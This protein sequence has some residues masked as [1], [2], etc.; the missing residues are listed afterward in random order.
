MSQSIFFYFP[1]AAWCC[2]QSCEH[3]AQ[4]KGRGRFRQS[5]H[6]RRGF[7]QGGSFLGSEA[8][9]QFQG[10]HFPQKTQ[11]WDGDENFQL[12]QKHD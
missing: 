6:Q 7:M 10:V 2:L 1:H 4:Q 12:K 11:N 5:I 3:R 9:K 8:S